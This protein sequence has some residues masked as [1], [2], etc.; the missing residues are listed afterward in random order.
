MNCDDYLDYILKLVFHELTK[1]DEK[2]QH[3]QKKYKEHELEEIDI[4][5]IDSD[6][7]SI[8]SENEFDSDIEN[9]YVLV[10]L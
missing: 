9:D 4:Y 7:I 6:E 5:S 10:N 8:I 2:C 1:W 3:V